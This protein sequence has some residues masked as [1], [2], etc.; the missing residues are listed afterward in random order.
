MIYIDALQDAI[1]KAH[2]CESQHVQSIPVRQTLRGQT[3]WEGVVEV[4]DLVGHP[5]AKQC[6]AWGHHAGRNEKQSHYTVV[7]RVSPVDSPADAVKTLMAPER[8]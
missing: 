4:F 8:K 3:V 6:Y 2:G 7:L 1:R 5:K